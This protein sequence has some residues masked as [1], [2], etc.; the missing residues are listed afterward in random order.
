EQG[1]IRRSPLAGHRPRLAINPEVCLWFRDHKSTLCRDVCPEEAI[2][3]D[4]E[5][6]TI[7]VGADAIVL[8]SGFTAYDPATKPRFGYG[9]LPNVITGLDLESQLRRDG[10]PRRPSDGRVPESVAFIQCVG[11]RERE[12]NNYCSR[13]CCG[14]ALRL[15]RAL[16]HRFGCA[17][18]V[19][20]MD[21]QSFGHAFDEF[22]AAAEEKLELIRQIP[23]DAWPGEDDRVMVQ[24]VADPRQGPTQRPFDLL[25]LSVGLAP[26]Q[27]NAGL[28]EM[29]GLALDDHGFIAEPEPPGNGRSPVFVAGA[30]TRPQDVSEVVAHASGAARETIRYLEGS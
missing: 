26:N 5:P 8:A 1:A 27:D 9:Q 2:R 25:V 21:I 24:Y 12:R 14:Y 13:V 20:Y 17:V 16:E 18:T 7:Q 15:G 6:E 10:E 11:S 4:L 23:G 30:V 29:L 28:A 19:F 22:L 3:F